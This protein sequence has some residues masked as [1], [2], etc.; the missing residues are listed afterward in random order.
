MLNFKYNF[1]TIVIYANIN[2]TQQEKLVLGKVR[3]KKNFKY[4]NVIGLVRYDQR[5]SFPLRAL[6]FVFKVLSISFIVN[7]ANIQRLWTKK[8]KKLQNN[9][10]LLVEFCVLVVSVPTWL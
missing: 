9:A 7:T 10:N 6:V 3:N 2:D 5:E 1:N 4:R 8:E